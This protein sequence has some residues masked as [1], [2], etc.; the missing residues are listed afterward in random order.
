MRR[1]CEPSSRSATTSGLKVV[2]EG[3]E[4]EQQLEFLRRNHCDELQ[5]YYFATPMAVSDFARV[6]F[7]SQS[8]RAP[9][10]ISA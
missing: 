9:D 1:S 5:G 10:R 8:Y 3:V 4:T 2:A 7:G 6:V